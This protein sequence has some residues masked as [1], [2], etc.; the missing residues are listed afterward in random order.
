MSTAQFDTWK[1]SGGTLTFEPISAW[2]IFDG[3]GTPSIADSINVSSITDNAVG[4]YDVNFTTAMLDTNYA[5]CGTASSDVATGT[6]QRLI[7]PFAKLTTDV[8]ILVNRNGATSA[9]LEDSSD[10][11]VVIIGGI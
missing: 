10:I 2:V 9:P 8:N 3:T 4:N 11:S 7:C 1:N 5:V 6:N